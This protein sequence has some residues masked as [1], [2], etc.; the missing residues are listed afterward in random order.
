MGK[1]RKN[2][3]FS[4]PQKRTEAQIYRE[5][6]LFGCIK[7]AD[8]YLPHKERLRDVFDRHVRWLYERDADG[9]LVR[10]KTIMDAAADGEILLQTPAGERLAI[11]YDNIEL[12]DK[13]GYRLCAND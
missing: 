3:G 8:S 4:Q 2:G 5:A 7:R 6:R 10:Y 12:L 13:E 1:Y 9:K 11:T